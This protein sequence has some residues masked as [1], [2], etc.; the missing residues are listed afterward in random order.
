M[1]SHIYSFTPYVDSSSPVPLIISNL[2]F[3]LQK[4]Y[5]DQHGLIFIFN[6]P[7]EFLEIFSF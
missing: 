2:C 6:I 7:F 3:L 5:I 4:I 1:Q